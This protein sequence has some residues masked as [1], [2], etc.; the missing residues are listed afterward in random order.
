MKA[1][2]P[3]S[4][5]V[6]CCALFLPTAWGA[7]GS[8]AA[9][10]V[11]GAPSAGSSSVAG[12]AGSP[13]L[14]TSG[15]DSGGAATGGAP[16]GFAGETSLGGGGSTATG[17]SPQG[18]S[19]GLAGNGAG[20]AAAGGTGLGGTGGAASGGMAGAAVDL[21]ATVGGP[22]DGKMLLGPCK[23]DTSKSVCQTTTSGCPGANASDP[24]L[25]G[26]LTTDS[27]VTLGGDPAKTYTI[28]IHVQ[29]VVESKRYTNGKDQEGQLASPKMDG[30]CEGGT[31]SGG[32]AYNVYMV[33]VSSPKKDYFLN[34]LQTP[35]VSNH[36]TYGID[37]TAKIQANGGATL[38]LV[39]ADSNCSM[40]K[41]CGP[42][43]NNGSVCAAPITLMNID[44]KATAKNPSFNFSQ[45]YNGQWIVMVVTAVV[46]N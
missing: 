15:S 12:S 36:T 23:N 31:P 32:D 44:P 43:E 11:V 19:V 20:G 29:G 2:S 37:Y 24:A 8:T 21:V 14:P 10:P 40:I 30:F 17:G 4:L 1:A 33:R 7:C 39:A 41:N 45:A 9:P 22:L 3:T 18:G 25:S 28:T 16:T 42:T 27:M 13:T 5:T 35:G 26:A 6:L 34:S 38:R 46:A